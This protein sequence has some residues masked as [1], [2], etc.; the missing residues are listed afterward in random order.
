MGGGARVQTESDIVFFLVFSSD[1][2]FDSGI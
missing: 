2:V 1:M